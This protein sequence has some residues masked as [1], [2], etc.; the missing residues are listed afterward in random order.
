MSMFNETPTGMNDI[1]MRIP[2]VSCNVPFESNNLN[3]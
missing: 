3:T 2:C 1:F